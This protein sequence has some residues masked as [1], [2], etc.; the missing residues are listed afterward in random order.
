MEGFRIRS[1]GPLSSPLRGTAR[2]DGAKN[3]ALK[4]MAAALLAPGTTVLSNVPDILDVAVMAQLLE[5]LGC[6]VTVEHDAEGR[7]TIE[8]PEELAHEAPYDL[9]RRLRASISVLGPLV[10][11]CGRARVA[12]PGGDNIGSRGL[13][14]HMT[15][16]QELG[17]S[18]HIEHG[19][20][21]AETSGG[22]S[23]ANLWLDFPSVGATENLLM[24]SVLT[25]GRTVIDNVAREPEIADLCTML[26]EMGAQIDGISSS[27]LTVEGVDRL[28]PVAHATVPDRIVAGTWAFAA[29]IAGG[30][31]VVD[32]ACANHLDIAL[33]KMAA[34]GA[35]VDVMEDGF[36]VY[37]DR[38]LEAFDV[39][40]LPY[41]GFPTDLQPF[42]M[43][44][45]AVSEGTAMITENVFEARFMFAQELARL[46]ADLR[47]DGHHAVVRG[48]AA[49]SGA[50]VVAHDIRAGAALVLAGLA[51][52]GTTEVAESHHIDRGYPRFAETLAGLGAD[53][54]RADLGDLPG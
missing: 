16:L 34:S 43:A 52:E 11:R 19:Y 2:V 9:V 21:V 12:L 4:L 30:D 42:A 49:L 54:T 14:M 36:R 10:A 27:T 15:G 7:V 8:V 35:T 25:P 46:G 22:L 20:V 6:R 17:A 51:A 24:A 40:T 45:A 28:R 29:A 44:L 13:D 1:K 47:T 26:V 53:V 38:R 48:R 39:V 50:P 33:D 31:L 18:V 23:G 5:Q 3:S 41:P 32:R 37:V